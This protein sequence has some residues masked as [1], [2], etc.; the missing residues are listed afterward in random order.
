MVAKSDSVVTHEAVQVDCQP[1]TRPFRE[2]ASEDIARIKKN[3]WLIGS[4]LFADQRRELRDTAYVL[5][6]APPE[7]R[8]GV[9]HALYI[10]GIQNLDSLGRRGSGKNT[11][12]RNQKPTKQRKGPSQASTH[13]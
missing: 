7:R 12:V 2:G 4:P 5:H 10:V 6:I 1:P 11:R 9:Q 8:Q 3:C 13:R